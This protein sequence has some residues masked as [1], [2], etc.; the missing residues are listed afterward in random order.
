MLTEPKAIIDISQGVNVETA[1]FPG[2]TPFSYEVALTVKESGVINLTKF[3]SSPHVGTHA[4]AYSHIATEHVGDENGIGNAPL[5][6]YIGPC[7]VIDFSDHREEI[8]V[9]M[10]K[11]KLDSIQFLNPR[12]LFKTQSVV[13]ENVFEKEYAYFQAELISFLHNEGVRL[14]GIDTPSVDH[15]DS[16]TLD[17][18]HQLVK[19]KIAWLENLNLKDAEEKNYFLTAA[20]VKY[21]PIEA[22]PVRAALLE[23]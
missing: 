2:D 18:H 9:D 16:K 11:K 13:R 17:T 22:A 14:I 4:D 6:P 20:P 15:I 1:C 21:Y 10:V 3:T 12:L 5:E 7:T 19:F 23:F 8:T